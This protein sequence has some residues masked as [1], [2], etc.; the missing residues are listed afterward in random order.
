[1]AAAFAAPTFGIWRTCRA[2]SALCPSRSSPTMWKPWAKLIM[3]R[4]NKRGAGIEQF[5]MTPGLNDSPRFIAA[6]AELVPR[7]AMIETY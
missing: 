1:M 7:P 3:K 2:K 5:E 4:A 6:L